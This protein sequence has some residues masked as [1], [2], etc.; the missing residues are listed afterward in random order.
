VPHHVAARRNA[1]RG[2]SGYSYS[3][4]TEGEIVGA[5]ARAHRAVEALDERDREPPL[6]ARHPVVPARGRSADPGG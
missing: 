2:Y 5:D 1:L 4:G 3:V 6:L